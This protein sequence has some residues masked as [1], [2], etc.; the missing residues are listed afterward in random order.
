M[1]SIL[2]LALAAPLLFLATPALPQAKPAPGTIRVRL[3]TSA[4]PIVLALDGKRA[5]KTT[6]NFLKYVDDGR[7]DGTKFYRSAPRKGDPKQ[8]F[9][10]G[11]V[12]T[13]ARRTL[14]PVVLEPTDKTGIRHLDG[15]VSMAHAADPNSATGN[16][17]I[18]VG[19][20]PSLDARGSYRGYAAFGRVVSGMDIV[21]KILALPTCCGREAMKGQMIVKPVQILRAQRLDGVPKPTGLSKPWL[22]N[23]RR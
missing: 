18:M 8:G 4:G 9:I 6:T 10:Q 7:L 1:R 3:V 15:V 16:F 22:L 2:G 19:P 17:S 12:G 5:P 13:D 23:I 14:S 11:G 20:N 21:R